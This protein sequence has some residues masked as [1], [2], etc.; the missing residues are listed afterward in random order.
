MTEVFTRRDLIATASVHVL[1]V[2]VATSL[3]L[4]ERTFTPQAL[5]SDL[6]T[7]AALATCLVTAAVAVGCSVHA[8]RYSSPISST[9]FWDPATCLVQLA[10]A[11]TLVYSL[12]GFAGAGWA[13]VLLL[14]P[15]FGVV[16]AAEQ[17]RVLAVAIGASLLG[18]GWLSGT[19]TDVHLPTAVAVV[20]LAVLTTWFTEQSATYMFDMRR[21][22]QRRQAAMEKRI[23]ELSDALADA[24]EGDLTG[25]VLAHSRDEEPAADSNERLELLAR[26]FDETVESL[27]GLVGSVRVGGESIGSAASQVL[28][29]AREQAL[30]ASEQSSA[31]AETTATIEELAATAAQIAETSGQVAVFASETLGFAEQGR[32]CGGGV[33]GGDGFD[34]VPGG[35][36]CGAGV[37]VGAEGSGDWSDF[38][39]D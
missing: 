11:V 13:L 10:A 22:A 19:L 3:W 16:F 27:R 1:L 24:A 5:R 21:Q 37:G 2:A 33:G 30:S 4:L 31:V 29:A 28:V 26:S 6:L 38:G 36:D 12:G 20:C 17:L 7:V 32:V 35:S 9:S 39:G 8:W 34:C 23:D 14:V 25:H 18:V 15:Y